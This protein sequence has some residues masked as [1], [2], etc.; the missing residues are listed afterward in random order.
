MSDVREC[1]VRWRAGRVCVGWVSDMRVVRGDVGDVGVCG[2]VT[3]ARVTHEVTNIGCVWGAC[4][5]ARG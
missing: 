3:G 5:L 1:G 2:G 4:I